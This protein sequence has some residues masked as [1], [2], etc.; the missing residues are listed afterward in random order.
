MFLG[1]DGRV[2]R[3]GLACALIMQAWASVTPTWP[4]PMIATFAAP[5]AGLLI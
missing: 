2:Q 4:A 5:D 3:D 1:C